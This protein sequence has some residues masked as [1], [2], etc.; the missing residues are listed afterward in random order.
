MRAACHHTYRKANRVAEPAARSGRNATYGGWPCRVILPQSQFL[1]LEIG[2][3]TAHSCDYGWKHRQRQKSLV[4]CLANGVHPVENILQGPHN[5]TFST[6][7]ASQ[8]FLFSKSYIFNF[9]N[10]HIFHTSHFPVPG[11]C[12]LLPFLGLQQICSLAAYYL[13]MVELWRELS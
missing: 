2:S 10:F 12:R 8:S 1:T 6:S 5:H 3:V 4:R 7:P 13:L 11:K 9:P